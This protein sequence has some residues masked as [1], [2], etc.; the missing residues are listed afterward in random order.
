MEDAVA[1]AS[2][3]LPVG[4][5]GRLLAAVVPVVA[6]GLVA[7]S[8]RRGGLDATDGDVVPP[9]VLAVATLAGAVVLSWRAATQRAVLDAAGLRC[10]NLLVSF[11]ADWDLVEVLRVERRGPFVTVDLV[12]AN[13]RRSHRIGAATRL[14]GPSAAQVLGLIRQVPAASARLGD[15]EP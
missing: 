7:A 12:L 9:W 6:F 1:P 8:A 15:P 10:R 5:P 4:L 14:A 13:L 11:E 3:E 2:V